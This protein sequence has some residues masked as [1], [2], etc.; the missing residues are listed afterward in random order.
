MNIIVFRGFKVSKLFILK[1]MKKMQ[2]CFF[3]AFFQKGYFGFVDVCIH[4]SK[5]QN[6]L[7]HETEPSQE[8]R[9]MN[10]I[11]DVVLNVGI[12]TIKYDTEQ[13]LNSKN[14]QVNNRINKEN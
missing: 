6:T 12:V 7:V 10:Y 11:K 5:I 4:K 2:K 13:T 9:R 14:N 8:I 1:I 3:K